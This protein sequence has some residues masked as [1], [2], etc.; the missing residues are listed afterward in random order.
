MEVHRQHTHTHTHIHTHTTT[1]TTH[2]HTTIRNTIRNTQHNTHCNAHNTAHT[3]THTPQFK[4][5]PST[6][7][8][9]PALHDSGA[10]ETRME[11]SALLTP[12]GSRPHPRVVVPQPCL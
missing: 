8:R 6:N 4:P 11:S 12:R 10:V 2:T 1:R 7:D 3:H 5:V 9:V